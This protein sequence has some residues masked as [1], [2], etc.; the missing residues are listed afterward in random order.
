MSGTRSKFPFHY[1]RVLMPITKYR[2]G[3]TKH[4]LCL[5]GI[6]VTFIVFLPS[7]S[8]EWLNWDDYGYVLNNALITDQSP[9]WFASLFTTPSVM[10]N[11]HPL[12]LLSLK[13]D[14][15]L[16]QDQAWFYHLH[17]LTIHLLVTAS[18]YY[19][20]YLLTNDRRIAFLTSLLFGIHPMHVEP[21]VWISARKELL[22]ALYFFISMIIYRKY[23]RNQRAHLLGLTFMTFILSLIS[24]ATAV[25]LPIILLAMDYYKDQKLSVGSLVQKIPFLIVS[26]LFGILA[27]YSQKVSDAVT[28]LGTY[29]L[30][31]SSTASFYAILTYLVKA[32]LPFHFSPYHPYPT[33]SLTSHPWYIY[34]SIIPLIGILYGAFRLGKHHLE[35]L[36]G[37]SFFMITILP[38]SQILAVGSA[39]T[40]ERYTYIPYFGLLYLAS[41]L[42]FKWADIPRDLQ[43][44]KKPSFLIIMGYIAFL[45]IS[46]LRYSYH[47]KSTEH[48]W[49]RVLEQYPANF[50]GYFQRGLEY[51][52][53]GRPNN[54]L[55][56]LTVARKHNTLFANILEYQS[57]AAFELGNIEQSILY[58][59]TLISLQPEYASALDL[60]GQMRSDIG[61]QFGAIDDLNRKVKLDPTDPLGYLHR[62]LVLERMGHFDTALLDYSTGLKLNPNL[63]DG[64][65]ARS[66]I[67]YQ[68]GHYQQALKDIEV[69][70]ASRGPYGP[71]YARKARYLTK[72]ERYD[73]ALANIE[74][75]YA[76]GFPVDS[77]LVE[78]IKNRE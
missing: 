75:A 42:F 6:A 21:V 20:T 78:T 34:A 73:E 29:S 11:Y 8:H 47:W 37:M 59:D 5:V 62:A 35:V 27:I 70:I 36:F 77:L 63:I 22:S 57:R 53:Q 10:G 14:F 19:L 66:W 56:D 39:L 18:V 25:T 67:L 2:Q 23:Q 38:V 32:F 48:L 44:W 51:L 61:D 40:S 71:A 72:V 68:L 1:I 33:L 7:L 45:S 46:T 28:D 13:F 4:F 43:G 31:Q 17:S 64:Y 30:L 54:A 3:F 76:L 26:L 69:V 24:K 58:L 49:T 50:T 12:T 41:S 52:R 15:M 16:A 65:F 60:R 55:R 74:K 9:G